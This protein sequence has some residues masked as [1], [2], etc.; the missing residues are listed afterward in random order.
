MATMWAGATVTLM[1]GTSVL[2]GSKSLGSMSGVEEG[3]R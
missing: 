1:V 2:R 3:E